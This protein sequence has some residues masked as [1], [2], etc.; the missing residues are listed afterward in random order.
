MTHLLARPH[1][2]RA[3]LGLGALILAAIVALTACGSGDT[4]NGGTRKIR[5]AS[6][7]TGTSFLAVTAGKEPGIFERNGI[8]IETIKVKSSAEATAALTSGQANVAALPPEGAIAA[9]AAGS[10]LKII[11][12]LSVPRSDQHP[13]RGSECRTNPA[14]GGP[15]V[16]R[17]CAVSPAGRGVPLGRALLRHVYTFIADRP[18]RSVKAKIRTLTHRVSQADKEAVIGRINQILPG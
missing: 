6:S 9:A 2:R 17:R 16:P 5:I 18:F 10:D 8:D 12:A 4:G 3:R 15:I 13:G 1:R 7:I 11:G 14:P